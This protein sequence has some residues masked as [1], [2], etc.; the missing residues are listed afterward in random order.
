MGFVFCVSALRVRATQFDQEIGARPLDAMWSA[1]GD[2][3]LN[4]AL[5]SGVLSAEFLRARFM[6]V[7]VA[8][9][10]ARAYPTLLEA[11][12]KYD[13]S[14]RVCE[15]PIRLCFLPVVHY[16][17]AYCSVERSVQ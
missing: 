16:I 12:R 13:A 17:C 3:L 11:T 6:A 1:Y 14:S 5:R 10:A 15:S 2:A 4:D 8:P 9:V 7:F